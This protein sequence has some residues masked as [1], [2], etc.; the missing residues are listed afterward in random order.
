M[1]RLPDEGEMFN[2]ALASLRGDEHRQIALASLKA[3]L[4]GHGPDRAQR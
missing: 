1:R 2:R 4:D 3:A